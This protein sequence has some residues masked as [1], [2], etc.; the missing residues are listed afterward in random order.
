MILKIFLGLILLVIILRLLGINILDFLAQDWVKDFFVFI[1]NTWKVIWADI[2][3]IFRSF[4][5]A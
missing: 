5:A 1:K 3:T 4:M 2:L